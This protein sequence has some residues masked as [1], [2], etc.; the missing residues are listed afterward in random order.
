M[1]KDVHG[2]VS[3][4]YKKEKLIMSNSY[5][6]YAIIKKMTKIIQQRKKMFMVQVWKGSIQNIPTVKSQVCKWA[7]TD[8]SIA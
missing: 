6:Q 1:Y 5:K 8:Y 4:K 7:K 3:Y 2:S